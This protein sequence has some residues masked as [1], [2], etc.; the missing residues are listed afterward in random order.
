MSEPN[1]SRKV[2]SDREVD[3]TTCGSAN[4]APDATV[5]TKTKKRLT[6]ATDANGAKSW[7]STSGNFDP[8]QLT[9]EAQSKWLK[10]IARG[11]SHV[12]ERAKARMVSSDCKQQVRKLS[13]LST[14]HTGEAKPAKK[15]AL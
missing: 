6:T 5:A 9:V 3:G 8:T 10:K 15:K 11:G 14:A 2:K 13:R 12:D 1:K 7:N 4:F